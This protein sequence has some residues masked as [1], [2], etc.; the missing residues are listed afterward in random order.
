MIVEDRIL[1]CLSVHPKNW[2]PPIRGGIVEWIVIHTHLRTVPRWDDRMSSIVD[3]ARVHA[4]H[5]ELI[6]STGS[7]PYHVATWPS[8]N[9]DQG[10]ALRVKTPHG[11]WFNS[12]SVA[13]AMMLDDPTEPP[14]DAQYEATIEVVACL[15]SHYIGS[16]IVGHT[17]GH[18]VPLELVTRVGRDG[19]HKVCPR[20][21]VDLE[22]IVSRA[23]ALDGDKPEAL[24][25]KL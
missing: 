14:T 2:N 18:D 16:Q 9:A 12:R 5:P 17:R 3:L 7:L 1:A 21:A 6:G 13:V 22:M 20:P 23:M 24:G 19:T 25:L 10:A 4:K 8:G 11:R 15:R